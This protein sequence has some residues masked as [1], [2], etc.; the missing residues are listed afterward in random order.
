MMK[1]KV[2]KDFVFRNKVYKKGSF[3]SLM[4]SFHLLSMFIQKGL[5][6]VEERHFEEV[7]KDYTNFLRTI[8][9]IEEPKD[10]I[11]MGKSDML[12]LLRKEDSETLS[13]LIE[14][15]DR[16]WRNKNFLKFCKRIEDVKTFLENK[17]YMK[18]KVLFRKP[19]GSVSIIEKFNP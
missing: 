2:E 14:I 3:I 16:E 18:R 11:Y 1:F 19:G 15:A 4:P 13:F 17:I 8:E 9:I 12:C 7:W 10:Y 6:K 5:I